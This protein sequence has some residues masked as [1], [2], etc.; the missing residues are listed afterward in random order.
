L[1]APIVESWSLIA[2]FTILAASLL[3]LIAGRGCDALVVD[4]LI[5]GRRVC[6][7]AI[8]FC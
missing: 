4:N 7:D 1:S 8:T 5:D 3:G 2:P 6:E